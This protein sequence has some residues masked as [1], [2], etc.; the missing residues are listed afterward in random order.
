ML[1]N[2]FEIS[3]PSFY[4]VNTEMA[5][6]LYQTAIDFAELSAD[7][8]V[9]DAYSGIGTIGLSFARQV[10]HVYG[11]E[12]VEKAV[13]DSQKNAARNGIENVTYVCDSAESAMKKWAT[14]GIKPTV[15]FVDPPRKGLT[16][17][18]IRAS[19]SVEPEKIVY[20][21]CNVATMARDVKLYEELGYRLTKVQPTDLFPNTHH[22][23][24]VG[25]LEK[26]I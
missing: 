13:L 16:D 11:V 19:A 8:V 18:F 12:M 6:K 7:D 2:E 14:A 4:Q 1:G 15:I 24:V 23:E 22:I 25:L 20:I 26:R 9:I 5:E 17:S 3:A 10:Q 21:S